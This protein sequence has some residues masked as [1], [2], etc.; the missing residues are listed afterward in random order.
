MKSHR[1]A[2]MGRLNVSA[3]PWKY[4]QLLMISAMNTR[5]SVPFSF[6]RP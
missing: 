6:D 3:L 5:S 1:H 2:K 4:I